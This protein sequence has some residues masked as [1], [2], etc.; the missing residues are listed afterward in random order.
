M[1]RYGQIW[2]GAVDEKILKG[3]N[4]GHCVV[5]IEIFYLITLRF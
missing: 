4:S 1:D 3:S 5:N 2:T